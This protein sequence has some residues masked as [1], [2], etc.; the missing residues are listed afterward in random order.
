MLLEGQQAAGN[1]NVLLFISTHYE[2]SEGMAS[3]EKDVTQQ[4]P[5]GTWDLPWVGCTQLLSQGICH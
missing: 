2:N 5:H 1:T 4:D 3:G